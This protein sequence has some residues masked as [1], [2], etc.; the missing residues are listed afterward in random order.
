MNL[1]ALIYLTLTLDRVFDEKTLLLH[2]YYM[3]DLSRSLGAEKVLKRVG[4][5]KNI[6]AC[7]PICAKET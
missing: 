1:R 2:C 7:D 6:A 5:S 4:V 3:G